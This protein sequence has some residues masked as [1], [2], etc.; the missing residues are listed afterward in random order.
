MW[1]SKWAAIAHPDLRPVTSLGLP[2][3]LTPADAALCP[4]TERRPGGSRT[5][6]SAWNSEHR[7]KLDCAA[8]N[9]RLTSRRGARLGK[10]AYPSLGC[11]GGSVCRSPSVTGQTAKPLSDYPRPTG[12]DL[13]RFVAFSSAEPTR[14]VIHRDAGPPQHRCLAQSLPQTSSRSPSSLRHRTDT[15]CHHRRNTSPAERRT[16]SESMRLLMFTA[17]VLEHRT[18]RPNVAFRHHQADT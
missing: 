1:I 9:W 10:P 17:R 7:S 13:H 2:S 14:V 5:A 3:E 16:A 15:F 18:A 12:V 6:P 4:L 11:C 8:A